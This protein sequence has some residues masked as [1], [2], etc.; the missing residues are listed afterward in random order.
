LTLVVIEERGHRD[1]GLRHRVADV[2]FDDGAHLL[3]DHRRHFGQ[4]VDLV[5]HLAAHRVVRAL[6]DV[7]A[8]HRLGLLHLFGEKVAADEPLARIDGGLGVGDDVLL[9]VIAHDDRAVVEERH[10]RRV[11]TLT[12]LVGDDLRHA[13]FDD[14]NA[15]VAGAEVD[16]HGDLFHR[17]AS[18]G[19]GRVRV[20]RPLHEL[21]RVAVRL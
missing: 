7:V 5:A 10:H 19:A 18:S 21:F 11:R 16:A 4:R 12:P 8:A 14:G 13:V 20:N 15:A 6:D 17:A 9:G 2:R 1:D 3:Q